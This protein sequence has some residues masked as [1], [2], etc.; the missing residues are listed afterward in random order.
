MG[1]IG[2]CCCRF[3]EQFGLGY[4]IE[5]SEEGGGGGCYRLSFMGN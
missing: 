1:Y 4:G 2:L 3:F 5:K